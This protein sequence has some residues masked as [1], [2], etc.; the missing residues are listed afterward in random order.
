MFRNEKWPDQVR[1]AVDRKGNVVFESPLAETTG[2]V[3]IGHISSGN[4][5]RFPGNT[6]PKVKRL[7]H[8]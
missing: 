2:R 5:S 6:R 7:R 3:D 4:I 1:G 8:A